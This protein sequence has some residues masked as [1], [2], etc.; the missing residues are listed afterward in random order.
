MGSNI[1]KFKLAHSGMGDM[2]LVKLK[3]GSKD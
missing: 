2:N 1:P 3:I